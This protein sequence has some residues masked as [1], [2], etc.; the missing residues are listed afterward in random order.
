MGY[1]DRL[2]MKLMTYRVTPSCEWVC[3]CVNVRQKLGVYSVKI[4]LLLMRPLNWKSRGSNRGPSILNTCR[5]G[6]KQLS[7]SFAARVLNGIWPIRRIHEKWIF[8][9]HLVITE[10]K[11]K[12]AAAMVT[13]QSCE[14]LFQNIINTCAMFWHLRSLQNYDCLFLLAHLLYNNKI[15]IQFSIIH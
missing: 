2:W 4:A 7:S 1:W 5:I 8:T 9:V 11:D 15:I 12:T 14:I 10:I 13:F 3:K 6:P